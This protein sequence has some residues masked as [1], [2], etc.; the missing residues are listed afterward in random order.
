MEHLAPL[1]IID[2]RYIGDDP[3]LIC[4]RH[5]FGVGFINSGRALGTGG[6]CVIAT[7]IL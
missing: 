2:D 7:G 4:A 5:M 1:S 6:E 3:L